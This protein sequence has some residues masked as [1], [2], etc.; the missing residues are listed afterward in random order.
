MFFLFKWISD[1]WHTLKVKIA[2]AIVGILELL[3]NAETTGL[4]DGISKAIDSITK[5]HIAENVNAIIKA[6]IAK[7]IATFLAIEDLPDN[8]TADDIQKFQTDITNALISK[9][10]Q[11]SV[12]GEVISNFGVQLFTII[13]NAIGAANSVEGGGLSFVKIAAAVEE[14]WQAYQ[15]DLA[16]AQAAQSAAQQDQ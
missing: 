12:P 9:K 8:P 6:N 1:A 15:T 14:A 13:Q 3:Q 4:M 7:G 11:Q 5:G 10:A 2:P 16:N